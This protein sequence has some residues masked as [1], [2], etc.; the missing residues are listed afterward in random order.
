LERLLKNASFAYLEQFLAL[1]DYK[2]PETIIS[3]LGT[4]IPNDVFNRA[5]LLP[6]GM[7]FLNDRPLYSIRQAW[8][9]I[10]RAG[11]QKDLTDSLCFI[12]F[13]EKPTT[14]IFPTEMLAFHYDGSTRLRKFTQEA[15][16]CKTDRGIVVRRRLLASNENPLDSMNEEFSHSLNAM[17]SISKEIE[18]IDD[19]QE[20][21][22]SKNE[23]FYSRICAV[24]VRN[25][26]TEK[27]L[28]QCIAPWVYWLSENCDE[29]GTLPSWFVDAAP[30]NVSI[31][32]KGD[33]FYFDR[34]WIKSKNDLK[35]ESVAFRGLFH[36]LLNVEYV[37]PPAFDDLT[38]WS[39]CKRVLGQ[40]D[41]EI[42][43]K[44]IK[45]FANN[46]NSLAKLI[47]G[48]SDDFEVIN[49][50]LPLC[51]V[52]KLPHPRKKSIWRRIAK[53]LRFLQCII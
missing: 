46:E 10:N 48:K 4:N 27:D 40:F 24:L 51:P 39:L 15:V 47:Y 17:R 32:E 23:T 9:V 21:V 34:E 30:F 37:S 6:R 35:L 16:F 44:T 14:Q 52:K 19:V 28:A 45:T 36:T 18:Q 3:P 29:N 26:W 13:C 41:L 12:A 38:V 25:G 49:V 43:I 11:L 22:Y 1:P 50:K 5:E 8:N 20:E 33:I 42:D 2:L 53:V 31:G 7:R